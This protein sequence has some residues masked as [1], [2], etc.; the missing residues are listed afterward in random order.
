MRETSS[1]LIVMIFLVALVD[2][3]SYGARRLLQR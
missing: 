1:I 3:V 2:L